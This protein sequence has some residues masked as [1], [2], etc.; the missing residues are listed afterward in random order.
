MTAGRAFICAACARF[1]PWDGDHPTAYCEAFPD[2]IPD[3]IVY[4]GFDHRHP[5][6]GDHGVLFLQEPGEEDTLRAY[7]EI[8]EPNQASAGS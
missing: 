2:G 5:H 8:I 3:D 1:R 6:A 7:E 4:G